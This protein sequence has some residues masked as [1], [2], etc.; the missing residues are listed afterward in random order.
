MPHN[1]RS[2]KYLGFTLI[3]MMVVIAIVG[4]LASIILVALNN[5]RMKGRDARRKTDIGQV[6]KALDL[7]FQDNASYPAPANC[8]NASFNGV[9]IQLVQPI[10]TSY[11]SSVPDDPKKTTTGYPNN[12]AY[13]CSSPT[14]PTGYALYVPLELE[15]GA[16]LIK[17]GTA[18]PPATF[19]ALPNCNF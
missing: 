1:V 19:A 3:E 2:K 14:G 7:Y 10:I 18:M 12:Y 13:A 15:G 16:C 8:S 9:D 17:G 6:R 5:A 11:I 4:F